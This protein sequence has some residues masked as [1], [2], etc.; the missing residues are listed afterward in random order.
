[1]NIIL[2]TCDIKRFAVIFAVLLLLQDTHA[3]LAIKLDIKENQ[4]N[5]RDTET[6]DAVENET[7]K[8]REK[9]NYLARKHLPDQRQ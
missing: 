7:N 3:K 8:D 2:R 4:R 9:S 1:M 6:K 5:K